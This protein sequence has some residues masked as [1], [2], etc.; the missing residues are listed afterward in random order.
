MAALNPGETEVVVAYR[1]ASA[2]GQPGWQLDGWPE[3]AEGQRE[4]LSPLVIKVHWSREWN[5]MDYCSQ[6]DG[7]LLITALFY[8]TV[9]I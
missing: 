8:V 7:H 6:R 9:S 5:V 3:G 1:K 2:L 4:C